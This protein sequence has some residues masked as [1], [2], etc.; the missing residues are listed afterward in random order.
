LDASSGMIYIITTSQD[1]NATE[2]IGLYGLIIG[3]T[4]AIGIAVIPEIRR[5]F[6]IG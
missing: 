6:L 5:R 4:I 3:L 2:G 1:A